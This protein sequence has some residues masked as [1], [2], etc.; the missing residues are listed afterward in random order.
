MQ[1]RLAG[2]GEPSGSQPSTE[3]TKRKKRP[4][5][6]RGLNVKT[7]EPTP[8]D[9]ASWSRRVLASLVDSVCL[10]ALAE[11]LFFVVRGQ[12]YLG[13]FRSGHE[14]LL[15]LLTISASAALYYGTLM[16]LTN[17]QT[18]GKRLVG[19]RVVRTDGRP[20]TVMRAL[21]RQVI[22]LIVAI[23]LIGYIPTA[24]GVLGTGVFLIDVLNPLRDREKRALHDMLAGTRVKVASA[25]RVRAARTAA[26][27]PPREPPP[28]NPPGDR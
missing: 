14:W 1:D 2:R 13:H 25:C 20:M 23:D 6:Y 28:D 17:G 15:R 19:I 27:P 16:P 12:S 10:V 3:R 18:L 5:R 24:G 9:F 21:W 7:T 22:L 8:G 11:G 26:A 4:L